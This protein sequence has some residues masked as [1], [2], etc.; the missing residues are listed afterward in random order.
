MTAPVA[1]KIH[2][3]GIPVQLS[4]PMEIRFSRGWEPWRFSVYTTDSRFDNLTNPVT[5][6]IETHGQA[7]SAVSTL[8]LENWYITSKI[9]QDE[10][11][12]KLNLADCRWAAE[13]NK[14]TASYNLTW[15]GLEDGWYRQESLN[16]NNSWLAVDAIKDALT[17]FGLV[18]D[19][20]PKLHPSFAALLLPKNLGTAPT[21]GFVGA[22]YYEAMSIMAESVALDIIAKPNGHVMLVDR[23]S[24]LT[25][26]M[27]NFRPIAGSA[28]YKDISWSQ[29][30]ELVVLFAKRLERRWDYEEKNPAATSS[31]YPPYQGN[32]I[33][34]HLE[35]V[36]P[37]YDPDGE[38]TGGEYVEFYGHV[39]DQVG[40]N[41]GV[42]LAQLHS[43]AFFPWGSRRMLLLNAADTFKFTWFEMM[44]QDTC[45]K[46]FRVKKEAL[47][48]G[49]VQR[50]L[51][52]IA[53][54][55]MNPDGTTKNNSSVHMDYIKINRYPYYGPGKGPE[56][57][58]SIFDAKFSQNIALD[59]NIPAPFDAQWVTDD[60]DD[61]IFDVLPRVRS[62]L[63]RNYW[64][65][66]LVTDMQYGS[67]NDV[68][69]GLPITLLEGTS[70][71]ALS[72]KLHVYYHGVQVA[73]IPSLGPKG[74]R[75]YRKSVDMRQ[76]F[77]NAKGPTLYIKSDAITANFGFNPSS[78]PEETDLLNAP[79]I[80]AAVEFVRKSVVDSYA[81]G[82]TGTV[83][84][85]GVSSVA[86]GK[87]ITGGNIFDT[88]VQ[89]GVGTEYDCV[90]TYILAPGIPQL[91]GSPRQLDGLAPRLVEG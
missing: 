28:N 20:N 69:Q 51:G 91:L 40:Y 24:N 34:G 60:V 62:V 58:G 63:D 68:V 89:L 85:S 50:P 71:L 3:D 64:A 22:A 52:S 44:I 2:I 30:T 10:G 18:V 5:I 80:D 23:I 83:T 9:R 56:A 88:V 27:N 43:A 79:A 36:I 33:D 86:D 47:N 14:L 42:V 65:G 19:D 25:G 48:A 4:A 61:L 72:F 90:T 13:F 8:I 76:Y 35:N 21:G 49:T 81:G 16:G 66:S 46:R 84:Y 39:E 53:F 45:R 57:G 7:N 15:W 38:I 6:K 37:K 31:T 74:D 26:D 67:I 54:G 59:D 87:I 75:V 73:D 11:G 77:A 1:T 17:R 41:R 70:I 29:P 78:Y 12:W 55:R 32:N 82:I